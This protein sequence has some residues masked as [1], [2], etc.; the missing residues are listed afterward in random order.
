MTAM[1]HNVSKKLVQFATQ[2]EVSVIGMEDLTGIRKRTESK[3][4][5]EF[6]YEHSSWAF[7]QLQGF[8]EYKAKEAGIAKVI[9]VNSEFTSQRRCPSTNC[10][11]IPGPI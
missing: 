10:N 8:V 7:R 11:H 2:N 3:V 5:K 6:R 9:Y 4:S 1:N